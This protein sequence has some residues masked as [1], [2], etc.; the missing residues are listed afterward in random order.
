M[1]FFKVF[2]NREVATLIWL[3]VVVLILCLKKERVK[4]FIPVVRALF[5]DKIMTVLF[6]SIIYVE[7]ILLFLATIKLWDLSFIKDVSF[8]YIGSGFV[9]IINSPKA[10]QQKK[11]FKNILIDN[12]KFIVLFEFLVNVYPFGLLTELILFPFLVL[13]ILI[14]IYA[15]HEEKHKPVKK[16]TSTLLTLFGSVVLIYS[17][18]KVVNDFTNFSSLKTLKTFSLPI[19]LTILYI[20]FI[21]IL[22][23]I[24]KYELMFI[25][26][27]FR[28]DNNKKLFKQVRRKIIWACHIN[29]KK[30]TRMD[31]L[32]K[33][34]PIRVKRDLTESINKLNN[35]NKNKF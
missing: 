23:L 9:M 26:I 1:D 8:W 14:D 10:N 19:I 33:Q 5:N 24:I 16:L 30:L 7:L 31:S 17:I 25:D 22:T 18:T 12:F 29:L 20:P 13:T 32:I 3:G 27:G 2:N 21:Y 35:F 4:A 15:N 34:S 11:P 28:I 6:L